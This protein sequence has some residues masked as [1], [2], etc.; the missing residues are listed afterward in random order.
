MAKGARWRRGESTCTWPHTQGFCAM[1]TR[2]LGRRTGPGRREGQ[3]QGQAG[4]Q[5]PP[6]THTLGLDPSSAGGRL[7]SG[8]QSRSTT[9]G[10]RDAE[11]QGPVRDV[12]PSEGQVVRPRQNSS[13]A[14]VPLDHAF[15]DTAP[16]RLAVR[17]CPLWLT[18]AALSPPCRFT[19]YPRL[20]KR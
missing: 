9:L 2:P 15:P 14:P 6:S 1:R 17:S 12:R 5:M 16:S 8:P 7:S 20:T 3:G 10:V 18:D 4:G 11:S 13:V 19:V